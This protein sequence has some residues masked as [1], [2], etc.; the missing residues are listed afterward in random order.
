MIFVGLLTVFIEKYKTF[1][2]LK[3]LEGFVYRI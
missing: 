1:Q 3:F 2:E